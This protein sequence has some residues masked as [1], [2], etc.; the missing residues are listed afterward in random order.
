MNLLEDC[1]VLAYI[2]I[3][4]VRNP[5]LLALA[6]LPNLAVRLKF[7]PLINLNTTLLARLP[8][9]TSIIRRFPLAFQ[10]L[11]F[12]QVVDWGSIATGNGSC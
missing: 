1:T 8:L 3:S 2:V 12:R 9:R 6:S 5:A 11:C 4:L 10:S 7:L